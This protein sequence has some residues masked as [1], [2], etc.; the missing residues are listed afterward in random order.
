MKLRQTDK[1][2]DIRTNR[3]IDRDKH[4]YKRRAHNILTSR[5]TNKHMDKQT[6][7]QTNIQTKT[8]IQTHKQTKG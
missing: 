1:Q 2:T 6:H 7:T 8:H 3:Q 5:N 4:I